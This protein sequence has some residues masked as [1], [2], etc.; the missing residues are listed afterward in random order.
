M[1][2]KSSRAAGS[3]AKTDRFLLQVSGVGLALLAVIVGVGVLG[4][5]IASSPSFKVRPITFSFSK[6]GWE[7]NWVRL[8]D[9]SKSFVRSEWEN[10]PDA[11]QRVLDKEVS[12]FTK[13]LCSK[14]ARAYS[15]NPWVVRVQRVRKV[16]PNRLEVDLQLREPFAVVD[17][18]HGKVV[19]DKD[20]FV[21]GVNSNSDF[22]NLSPEQVATLGPAA[23]I[24]ANVT[25]A[26]VGTIW[27]EPSVK[28]SIEMVRIC[29]QYFS[30]D[31]A[32]IQIQEFQSPAGTVFVEAN[33]MLRGGPV[34]QWGRTLA[35][36]TPV[37]QPSSAQKIQKL[38]AV[39]KKE[40]GNVSRLKRIDLTNERALVL[41]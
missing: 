19:V 41:R 6:G 40:G 33:L 14:V 27:N 4:A 11:R 20:G 29:R 15:Y 31:V 12:I 32:G 39:L 35:S 30:Q 17:S 28:G 25:P 23:V 3:K 36:Q 34:V 1:S 13:G 26:Q 18:P 7:Q 16:F 37:G 10:E 22:Y 5:R 24:P 8:N 9:A 2:T 21:L 38:R